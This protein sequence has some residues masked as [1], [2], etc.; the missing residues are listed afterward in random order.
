MVLRNKDH[1]IDLRDVSTA[2]HH[3]ALLAGGGK[4]QVPCLRVQS[5]DAEDR[6]MYESD[7]IISYIQQHSLVS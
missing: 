5:V 3:Q 6:W 2:N 1:R 4:G 7:D